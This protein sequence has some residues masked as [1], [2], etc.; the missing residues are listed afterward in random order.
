[1]TS[2]ERLKRM[3]P[4]NASD[5][6]DN[7]HPQGGLVDVWIVDDQTVI[8]DPIMTNA[9]IDASTLPA[10]IPNEEESGTVS[11]PTPSSMPQTPSGNNY[12]THGTSKVYNKKPPLTSPLTTLRH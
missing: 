6:Y 11:K 12:S 3:L 2:K 10:K 7:I 1:M 8:C 9:V 5:P 4:D